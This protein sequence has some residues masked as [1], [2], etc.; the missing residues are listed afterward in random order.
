MDEDTCTHVFEGVGNSSD[1]D[2]VGELSLSGVLPTMNSIKIALMEQ[3]LD[4]NA[5]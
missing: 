5:E 3:K 1:G 4:E 2:N